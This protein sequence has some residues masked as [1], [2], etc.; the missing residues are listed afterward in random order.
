MEEYRSSQRLEIVA[1][2]ARCAAVDKISRLDKVVPEFIMPLN[3][4]VFGYSLSVLGVS[5]LPVFGRDDV[6]V[7]AVEV[8]ICRFENAYNAVCDPLSGLIDSEVNHMLA[9]HIKSEGAIV[10]HPFLFKCSSVVLKIVYVKGKALGFKP[11]KHLFALF[12]SIFAHLRKISVTAGHRPVADC[13]PGRGGFVVVKGCRIPSGVYPPPV[14][15]NALIKQ[16]VELFNLGVLVSDFVGVLAA[17]NRSA[18]SALHY[19]AVFILAHIAVDDPFSPKIGRTGKISATVFHKSNGGSGYPLAGFKVGIEGLLFCGNGGGAAVESDIRL[20]GSRP[21]DS[22]KCAVAAVLDIIIGK[23][24]FGRTA[25][26]RS[27]GVFISRFKVKLHW[28]IGGGIGVIYIGIGCSDI[29]ICAFKG[30][31]CGYRV[32]YFSSISVAAHCV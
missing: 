2:T 24:I 28:H 30:S 20:P 16:I 11:Q 29:G 6:E 9:R 3:A 31:L 15:V 7:L 1:V 25:G 32:G 26:G 27:K 5:E 12:V 23:Y 8:E 17:G 21:T 22:H 18:S 19:L 4:E 13:C 14:K 10:G